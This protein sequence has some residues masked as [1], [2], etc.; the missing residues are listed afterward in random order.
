MVEF[1]DVPG[2]FPRA[3]ADPCYRQTMKPPPYSDG[4]LT[5]PGQIC[6][7]Q[8]DMKGAPDAGHRWE[9]YRNDTLLSWSWAALPSEASAFIIHSPDKIHTGRLLADTD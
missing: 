9:R 2:A 6:V 7:M 1:W 8:R 5:A 4:T 3:L